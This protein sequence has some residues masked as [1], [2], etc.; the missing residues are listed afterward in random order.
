MSKYLR[1]IGRRLNESREIAIVCWL[2]MPV[3]RKLAATI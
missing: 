1:F 2:A 3:I